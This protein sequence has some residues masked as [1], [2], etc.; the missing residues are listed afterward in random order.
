MKR[1]IRTTAILLLLVVAILFWWARR[2]SFL[3]RFRQPPATA[4]TLN[5]VIAHP[6]AFAENHF[7]GGIGVVLA[8]DSK[9]GLASVMQVIPGS[10]AEKAGLC[11]GDVVMKINGTTT[12]GMPLA[13]VVDELRGFVGGGVT[14]T[15]QRAGTNNLE[16]I[17]HRKSWSGLGVPYATPSSNGPVP[18]IPGSPVTL[19]AGNSPAR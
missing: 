19:P 6:V 10:P 17:L 2:S 15:I 7:K 11:K 5:Q 3:N 8:F 4:S 14:V 9:T 16:M 1:S 18:A 12:A 13:Q